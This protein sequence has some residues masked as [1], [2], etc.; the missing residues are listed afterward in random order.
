MKTVC[1][2]G[3]S[4]LATAEMYERVAEI[5][6][7]DEKR[8]YIVASAPGK[9]FT[10]D[11]KVTDLFLAFYD[12]RAKGNS[13]N[14]NFTLIEQR[15]E[16]ICRKLKIDIGLEKLLTEIEREIPI[17]VS[18]VRKR[19][20]SAS[21]GEFLSAIVLAKFLGCQFVDTFDLLQMDP[22]G[23]VLEE[24]YNRIKNITRKPGRFVFP[25]FYGSVNTPQGS[26]VKTF[27]RGG[28]DISGSV[29]ARGVE[30]GL[31]ENWTD[32]PLLST[33]PRVVPE[34]KFISKITY[35]ELR[36]LSYMGASVFHEEAISPAKAKNIPIRILATKDPTGPS[37]AIV[38]KRTPEPN[39]NIIGIAG[40]KGFTRV[41]LYK[42]Q[43]HNEIGI[44]ARTLEVFAK[45]NVSIEHIPTG[46]DIM[47]VVVS[48]DNFNNKTE[49]ITKQIR[50][51]LGFEEISVQNGLA[52]IA[53]VGLGMVN[54]PG[55][56]GKIF[57]VLGRKKINVQLILQD[58]RETTIIIGISDEHLETAIQSLYQTFIN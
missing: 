47:S 16:E 35:R 23:K 17:G 5:I 29:I 7:A 4:S 19:D 37:T 34:A 21:R 48:S 39:E 27:P 58:P 56:S 20:Y 14:S 30:A 22:T 57:E 52:L 50:E 1:K 43:M 18:D 24:S 13:G 44:V 32:N 11:T 8:V 49:T 2:F 42:E 25:G 45:H 26:Y 41:S 33:D 40:K 51:E 15:F 31:Y 55:T 54:H 12:E 53:V 3:G 46:I 9:R 38:E 28:S 6:N 10:S 36:E